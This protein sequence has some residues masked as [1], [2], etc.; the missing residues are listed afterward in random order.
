[1]EIISIDPPELGF[2]GKQLD[3][4]GTLVK[5]HASV[6]DAAVSEAGRRIELLICSAPG[7]AFNLASAGAELHII[8]R[9]HQVTDLPMYRHMKGVPFKDGKTMDQRARGYGG[10]HSCCS[11]DSVLGLASA[12]HSDHRDICSHEFAHTVLRYGLDTDLHSQVAKRY[13]TARPLWRSA[14][15][16][17]NVDEF[18][19]ELTMWYVGSRGDYTS[20]RAPAPGRRW[21]REHDPDS[22]AL[23]DAIYSGRLEPR[24]IQWKHLQPSGVARSTASDQAVSLLFVNETAGP[25]ERFWLNYSGNRK[26]YGQIP[27]GSVSSQ[28]TYA[29]HAWLVVSDDGREFGP[30]VAGA[31]T[32]G[33]VRI[34]T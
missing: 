9:K 2:Y 30:F 11:E 33:I 24:R 34:V 7:V 8:H 1:M 26:G 31:A 16:S 12:R 32:H 22:F 18:F 15:A 5:A 14:Y 19:A 20:L 3:V 25:I 27:A 29:T 4:H 28:S 21:L 10:L 23:L 13:A 17:T 6:D